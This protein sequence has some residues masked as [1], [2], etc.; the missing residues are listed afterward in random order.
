MQDPRAM[1]KADCFKP[2][3]Q[4]SICTPAG[5]TPESGALL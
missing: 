5:R 2:N 4:G 3:P 1:V